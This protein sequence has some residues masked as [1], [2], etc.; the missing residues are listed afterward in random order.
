MFRERP[1]FSVKFLYYEDWKA[2]VNKIMVQKKRLTSR[3][4]KTLG[5]YSVE[6]VTVTSDAVEKAG[7]L[8]AQFRVTWSKQDVELQKELQMGH[9]AQDGHPTFLRNWR[10]V[11]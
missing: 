10:A 2:R 4:L 1:F 8:M 6:N 5:A 3:N 7:I 11:A 9:W